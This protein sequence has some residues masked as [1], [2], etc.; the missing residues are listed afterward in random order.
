MKNITT[1]VIVDKD[2]GFILRKILSAELTFAV[3]IACKADTSLGP[4]WR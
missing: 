4:N 1:V 2:A 3:E